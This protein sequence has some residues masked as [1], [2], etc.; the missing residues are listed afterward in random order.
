MDNLLDHLQKR[1]VG[2]TVDSFDWLPLSKF[3]PR[4]SIEMPYG[5]RYRLEL[6]SG[7]EYTVSNVEAAQYGGDRHPAHHHAREQLIRHVYGK[8]LEIGNKLFSAVYG[9]ASRHE[10]TEI[11]DELM[12]SMR[13]DGR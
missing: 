2:R 7:V 13:Y 3:D 10:I 8:Q 6:R 4:E 1:E 11:V 9:G 12:R 5:T